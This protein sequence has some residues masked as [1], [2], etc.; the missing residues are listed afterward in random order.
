MQGI[1]GICLD[2]F[3]WRMFLY[4][5]YL[6][7][8]VQHNLHHHYL[9]TQQKKQAGLPLFHDSYQYYLRFRCVTLFQGFKAL[10]IS[11][12]KLCARTS[13]DRGIPS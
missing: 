10:S 2:V 13:V 7:I 5:F 6:S 12:S 3:T 8:G 9:K 11:A 4:P 1:Y